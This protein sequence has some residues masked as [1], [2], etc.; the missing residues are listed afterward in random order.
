[1]L[2]SES[3]TISRRRYPL[4]IRKQF[5]QMIDIPVAIDVHLGAGEPA[6]VDQAGVIFGVGENRI[7]A[8]HQCRDRA[9]VRGETGAEQ[10]R[11]FRP[12]E[13]RKLLLQFR[14]RR[15]M[16]RDQ[17]TGPR[18]PTLLLC[19]AG[20]GGRQPRIGRQTEIIVRAKVHQG[21]T[22]QNNR[23]ALRAGVR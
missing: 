23:R 19:R 11:G 8:L 13:F 10:Q 9:E 12:L 2:N 7:A 3:V 20:G 14:M 15:T 4:A 1:M 5:A 6:A 22:I 17:R 16:A 21:L 18:A